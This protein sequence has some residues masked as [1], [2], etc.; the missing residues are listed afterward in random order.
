MS[1]YASAS[2]E[3]EQLLALAAKRLSSAFDELTDQQ[4]AHLIATARSHELFED[5]EDRFDDE[6]DALFESVGKQ[7]EAGPAALY[8][9]DPDRRFTRRQES[10]EV[11]PPIVA[12]GISTW[13]AKSIRPQ[14]GRVLRYIGADLQQASELVWDH[15]RAD[16][17]RSGP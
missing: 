5:D 2:A 3:C 13:R 17:M 16:A 12:V 4:L 6:A 8:N 7:V 14:R 1:A 15:F 9:P 10:L 11:A